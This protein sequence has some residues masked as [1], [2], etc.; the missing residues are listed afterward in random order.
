MVPLVLKFVECCRNGGLRVSTSEVLDS[1]AHLALLDPANEQE[2]RSALMANFAKSRR[3]QGLF[4][5]MYALFFHDL[6]PASPDAPELIQAQLSDISDQLAQE[7]PGDPMMEALLSFASGDP[8]AYIEA[9]RELQEREESPQIALKSNMGQLSNRLEVMLKIN[10]LREKAIALAGGLYDDAGDGGP[11]RDQINRLMDAAYDL[12]T[13]DPRPD[14]AGLKE[15][16]EGDAHF[17]SQL[18]ERPFSNLSPQETAAMR[19]TVNRLVKKLKDMVSRRYLSRD[20]G[21]L[22]VK[23]TLRRAGRFQGV[24]VEI[25]FKDKPLRKSNIV[26]I[27]DVSS[28]VWSAARFMLNILYSLQDCFEK[29]KSFVFVSELAEITSFFEAYEVNDAIE[30]V[31][32]ETGIDYAALTDYGAMFQT[33]RKTYLHTLNSKTTLIIIGDARSNYQNPK[34]DILEELR[35]KSR[36]V[37]WLNPEAEVTWNTGDSEMYTYKAHCHEIRQCRNL[38]QLVSFIEDLV[39]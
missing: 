6:M 15:V 11:L 5:Q 28:S 21:M 30:K 4:D 19:E 1:L 27:C 18:G 35:A 25:M 7:M 3:E 24:P 12:L 20:R 17:S 22:D 33:F 14:N 23:K 39:L 38:N 29:V 37:I 32:R 26:A 16:K 31:L 34:A 13:A 2:F 8:A 10:R 36:R 9:V